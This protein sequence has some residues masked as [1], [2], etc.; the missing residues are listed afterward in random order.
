MDVRICAEGPCAASRLFQC[1]WKVFK[2]GGSSVQE[3]PGRGAAV[4]HLASSGITS[5]VLSY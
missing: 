3:Q 2:G 1:E 4:S 5:F